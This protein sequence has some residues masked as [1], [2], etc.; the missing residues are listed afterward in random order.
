[1]VRKM[2][3]DPYRC[4]AAALLAGSYVVSDTIIPHVYVDY[5]HLYALNARRP[6]I[7]SV[8]ASAK[9]A[10]DGTLS[11]VSAQAEDTTVSTLLGMIPAAELIKGAVAA[12]KI[13]PEETFEL[14][15]QEKALKIRRTCVLDGQYPE[16]RKSK[17]NPSYRC[18]ITV[19][20]VGATQGETDENA[21]R[22]RGEIRMPKPDAS[23]ND[24]RAP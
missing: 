23:K 14:S 2:H 17:D 11:E 7:G 5:K 10:A 24:S 20:E 13:V 6:L 4:D 8:Q 19:E 22:I 3:Y 1:M 12:A 15:I 16:C 9:V 18:D 21:I